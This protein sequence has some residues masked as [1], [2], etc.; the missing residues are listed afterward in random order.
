MT[1]TSLAI[2]AII[3]AVG[4]VPSS[5]PAPIDGGS[6]ARAGE[7]RI[8]F[9]SSRSGSA[10]IYIMNPDGSGLRRLTTNSAKDR[11]PVIS[12]AHRASIS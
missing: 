2:T 10:Q 8:A 5:R 12:T 3:I 7:E 9:Y 6:T 4:S 11:S 1:R